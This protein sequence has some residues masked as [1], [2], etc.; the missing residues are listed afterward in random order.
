MIFSLIDSGA[1]NNIVRPTSSEKRF[2]ARCELIFVNGFPI[3]MYGNR[4]L[5]LCFG[6]VSKFL[7]IFV[8]A[9][10]KHNILG[11]DFLRPFSLTRDFTSSKLK[12]HSSQSSF[13]LVTKLICNCRVSIKIF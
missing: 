5:D 7:W 6:G 10:A 13:P 4:T 11:I 12:S 1:E 3:S 9:D 8:I 2:K